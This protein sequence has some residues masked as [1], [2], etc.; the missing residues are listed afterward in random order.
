MTRG[1]TIVFLVVALSSLSG[2]KAFAQ[3]QV[4]NGDFDTGVLSWA[5]GTP[6]MIPDSLDGQGNPSSGS[7][8]VT[9][10]AIGPGTYG[11]NQIIGSISIGSTYQ[12][13]GRIR[14]PPGQAAGLTISIGATFYGAG[15]AGVLGGATTSGILTGGG[16]PFNSWVFQTASVV[17]PA[18]A[19]CARVFLYFLSPSGNATPVAAYF[20]TVRFG[21]LPT[22]P[23]DL[24][25]FE[26][27]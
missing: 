26:V 27:D 4:V 14:V 3:N 12:F 13:G 17:A 1:T 24:K 15:C 16:G 23:V 10:P 7:A 9:L 11:A 2:A 8:L 25:S 18:G 21:L 20:D 6:A 19:T 22:T 5:P